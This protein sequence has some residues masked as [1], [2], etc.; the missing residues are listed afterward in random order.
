M[1]NSFPARPQIYLPIDRWGVL[2]SDWP[3]VIIAT[4]V[5]TFVPVVLRIKFFGFPLYILSC[6]VTFFGLVYFFNRVR[7][8]KPNRWLNH[9]LFALINPKILGPMLPEHPRYPST[10]IELPHNPRIGDTK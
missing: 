6:P 9:K 4:M 10:R 5:A 3:Y 7:I 1:K 2:I 8:G